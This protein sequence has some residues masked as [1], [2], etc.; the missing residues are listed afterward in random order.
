VSGR[1]RLVALE[2][3]DGSGKST[4]ARLLADALGALCTHEPGSTELG[5]RLRALILDTD[6]P[7]VSPRAEALLLAADR[8]QHVTEVVAPALEAGRWVVTERF[9][10][11]TLAYQGHGRGMDLG[12]LQ[13]LVSWAA[14]DVRP[15]LT[16]LID[17]PVDVARER[18]RTARPDRLE[19]LD[20]AFHERVR[21]GYLSLAA[22]DPAGWAVVDGTAGTEA[23][24]R[25]LWAVVAERLGPLPTVAP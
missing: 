12:E 15:D 24:A 19:R 9:S 8:A 23:V 13:R 5:A 11:S 10:A 4:H 3:I 18:M 21:S 7:A 6:G 14:Q 17:V 16:V 25:T 1:G 2:G 22:A 20:D